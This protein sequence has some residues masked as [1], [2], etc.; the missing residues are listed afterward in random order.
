MCGKT[1]LWEL[2]QEVGAGECRKERR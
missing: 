2:K 1:Q